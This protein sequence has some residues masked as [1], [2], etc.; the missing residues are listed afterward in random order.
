VG[1]AIAQWG[2]ATLRAL[3]L[4][5]GSAAV[6][7]DGRTLGF[8]ALA[9][10]AAGLLTGIIPALHAG[11]GDV[12]SALKAGAREGSYQP[13]RARSL[14]LVFQAALSVL[15]LVGAG[16]FVRSLH[17]VREHRLGYD[18]EPVLFAA[19][20]PRGERLTAAE[21]TALSERML[22]EAR[23]MP[24]VTSA[25]LTISVPFWSNEG[26]GIFVP[27]VDSAQKLGRFILQ[28]ASPE[29]FTTMGTRILRGR[30]FDASDRAGT[31][32][33]IVVGEAMARVLWPGREALGQC[34]KLGSDSVPCSTVIGVAEEMRA[35]SLA[36]AREFSYYIPLAQYDNPPDGQVFARVSGT[37]ADQAEALRRRLQPLMPGAAYVNVVPLSRLV[38]P[39]LQAWRF[40]TTMFVAFGGLAL[41][42][43]AIGLY[44][45]ISYDVAQRTRELGVR[46]ALGSSVGRLLRLIVASG[47]RL[48]FLGVLAGS[49]LAFWAARWISALLFN[50]SPRDPLVFG[51]VAVLLLVVAVVACL[52]PALRAARVDPIEALR[53]E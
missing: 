27:G 23:A 48:V 5:D 25:A 4:R 18:V 22:A 34:V 37:A 35:R 36:D 50:E 14:L 2:A 32:P 39:N 6:L 47:L 24:G 12:A 30:A 21:R 26:R 8:T 28:A 31:P 43:A 10:L 38:D 17:N 41:L 40:G 29:Y 52:L 33:V 51:G 46:V 49:A 1:L 15:L 44:S 20:N 16:L 9:T 19:A 42:L 7:V 53:L 13:S 11:R 45:M 3:F